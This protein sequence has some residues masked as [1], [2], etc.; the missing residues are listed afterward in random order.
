MYASG[1]YCNKVDIYKRRLFRAWETG[2]PT[3][4]INLNSQHVSSEKTHSI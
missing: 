4:G 1:S 2:Q 3:F